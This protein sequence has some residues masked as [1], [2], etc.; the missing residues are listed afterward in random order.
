M[1]YSLLDATVTLRDGRR[2]RSPL[3]VTHTATV[4]A[5]AALG[6]DWSVGGTARYG[7]GAPVTPV[8]GG[9]TGAEGRAE[10][11]YGAL[12]SDRLPD[13]ARLDARVM[14]YVHAPRWLLTVF[15][16]GINLAGRANASAA[17]YDESY[18]V[19]SLVPTFFARRTL[20][21]GAEVRMR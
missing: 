5:T 14:R 4:T 12:M 8:L 19:R 1:S 15:A 18:R 13:Y 10:P 20:V 17:T 6:A 11:V 7:T 9:R 16:E 21:V 2:V 3:D